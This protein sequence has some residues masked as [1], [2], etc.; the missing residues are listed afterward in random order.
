MVDRDT[1]RPELQVPDATSPCINV[2]QVPTLARSASVVAFSQSP[3]TAVN[4]HKNHLESCK[5]D[6]TPGNDHAMSGAMEL[7]NVRIDSLILVSEDTMESP[8]RDT[9]PRKTRFS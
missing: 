8:L 5:S 9:N 7:K 1:T 4:I 3:P 6:D 2:G